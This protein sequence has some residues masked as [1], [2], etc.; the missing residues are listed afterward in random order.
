VDFTIDMNGVK[1]LG[2]SPDHY[3]RGTGVDAKQAAH[4][5]RIHDT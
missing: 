4:R 1:L 3:L 5:F 2:F